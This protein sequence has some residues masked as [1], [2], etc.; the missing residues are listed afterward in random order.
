MVPRLGRLLALFQALVEQPSL[1]GGMPRGV[2]RLASLSA[3]GR[4]PMPNTMYSLR[5]SPSNREAPWGCKRCSRARMGYQV[6][7]AEA[8]SGLRSLAVDNAHVSLTSEEVAFSGRRGEDSRRRR[9][10]RIRCSL[11]QVP[12]PLFFLV[13]IR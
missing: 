3:N 11:F 4:C 6:E 13:W 10:R 9:R 12:S 1:A 5:P 7:Q 2:G 8:V